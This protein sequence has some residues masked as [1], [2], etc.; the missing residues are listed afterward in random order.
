MQVS[1]DIGEHMDL[2]EFLDLPQE[3]REELV[4]IHNKQSYIR[5]ER[6]GIMLAEKKLEI[7]KINLQN[8]CEHPNVTK[9]AKAD[10]GNFCPQD[11]SYWYEFR[12]PDCGKFWTEPQRKANP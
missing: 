7:R 9:T 3:V 12:C 1:L 4:R 2:K 6:E 11:D 5:T 10:T 8:E